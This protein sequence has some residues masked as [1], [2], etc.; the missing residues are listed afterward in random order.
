MVARDGTRKHG[1]AEYAPASAAEL[2][3][4]AF[5]AALMG[6]ACNSARREV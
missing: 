4:D 1:G 2:L 6:W 5:F 3:L